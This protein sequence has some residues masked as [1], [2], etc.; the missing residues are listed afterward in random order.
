MVAR[1]AVVLA[2][3]GVPCG[4]ALAGALLPS[5]PVG[6]TVTSARIASAMATARASTLAGAQ[7]E[8]GSSLAAS[9]A[10]NEVTVSPD[11]VEPI[12]TVFALPE[13]D[14]CNADTEFGNFGGAAYGKAELLTAGC[15]ISVQVVA[16]QN[17]TVVNG[18]TASTGYTYTWA[19]STVNP[20]YV[21]GEVVTVCG[22][23]YCASFSYTAF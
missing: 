2:G 20:A 13:Y 4:L 22:T 6:A 17:G 7:S 12:N 8:V 14:G 11:T 15:G 9:A 10:V 19:Q 16:D 3:L 5:L 21:I 1:R 18:A 23:D